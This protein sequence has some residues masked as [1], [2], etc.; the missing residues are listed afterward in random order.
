MRAAALD[1]SVLAQLAQSPA[2]AP[3]LVRLLGKGDAAL[4]EASAAL[5][6][7]IAL[8]P[9]G[10]EQAVAAGAVGALV[11]LLPLRHEPTQAAAARALKNLAF[12]ADAQ[13]Q[14]AQAGGMQ[15]LVRLMQSASSELHQ[16]AAAAL[17]VLTMDDG[18]RAALLAA[19]P[20]VS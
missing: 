18:R 7:T 17:E 9:A 16:T 13:A 4:R 6:G 5:L 8:H 14:V 15:P 1:P 12:A 11:R 2:A 20:F 19:P 10:R 3:P